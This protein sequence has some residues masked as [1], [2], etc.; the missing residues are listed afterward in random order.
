MEQYKINI[1]KSFS[2]TRSDAVTAHK[3]K[4]SDPE[5]S[6]ILQEGFRLIPD[7]IYMFQMSRVC[8][9]EINLDESWR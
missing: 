9:C 8:L 2:F 6:L 3:T 5:V 7:N 1:G 4:Q